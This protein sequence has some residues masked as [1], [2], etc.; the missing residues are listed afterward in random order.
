MP[1]SRA[2]KEEVVA[3]LTDLFGRCESAVLVD[4]GGLS[5]KQMQSIRAR[6]RDVGSPFLVAKN[7]LIE[8]A[9]RNCGRDL[10][11][12]GGEDLS[13]LLTGMTALAFG[14]DQPNAPAKLLQELV[15]EFPA[16]GLKGGFYGRLPVAGEAGVTQI[17]GMR[18][19]DDALGEL[20]WLLNPANG[21]RRVVQI[22]SAGPQR[23]MT[24]AA[25]A[26]R[27]LQQLQTLKQSEAA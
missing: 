21:L 3:Q 4:H 17:A 27:A 15:V 26:T 18:S 13:Y 6:L 20:V 8:L 23:V 2:K 16:L 7:K 25:G 14:F 1:I 12:A 10:T 22:A 11:G 24:T 9:L 19:K 5:V